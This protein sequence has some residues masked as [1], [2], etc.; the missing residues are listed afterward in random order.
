MSKKD[1]K[2]FYKE[3]KS[4]LLVSCGLCLIGMDLVY[5]NSYILISGVV[6]IIKSFE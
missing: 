4:A 6:L 2:E 3:N 1:L 5:P